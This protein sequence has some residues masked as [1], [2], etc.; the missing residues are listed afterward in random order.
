MSMLVIQY[1]VFLLYWIGSCSAVMAPRDGSG[2][3]LGHGSWLSL[4]SLNR[5]LPTHTSSSVEVST[6]V[7]STSNPLACRRPLECDLTGRSGQMSGIASGSDPST[8]NALLLQSGAVVATGVTERWAK[9]I[10]DRA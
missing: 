8:P 1:T 7:E 6:M 3:R 2:H 5:C 10:R 4:P 9:Q